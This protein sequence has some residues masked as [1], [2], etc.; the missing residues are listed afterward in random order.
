MRICYVAQA[1]G[2]YQNLTLL[3]NA[4]AFSYLMGCDIPSDLGK[5][6]YI[7]ELGLGRFIHTKTAELSGGFQR[8][9]AIACALAAQPQGLFLDE[10]LGGVDPDHTIQLLSRLVLSSRLEFLVLTDHTATRFSFAD[11]VI[12][13][14]AEPGS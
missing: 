13:L 11:R 10:P 12:N 8:L 1:G 5:Q 4:R 2:L 14:S 6:W 3:E 9:A 7:D